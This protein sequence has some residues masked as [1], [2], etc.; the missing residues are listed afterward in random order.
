MALPN[1][2]L[3]KITVNVQGADWDALRV[4]HPTVGPSLILRNIL[5]QYVKSRRKNAPQDL[6]INL[7]DVQMD[8]LLETGQ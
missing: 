5:T 3:R 1:T 7:T 2:G 4:L 6:E 8:G